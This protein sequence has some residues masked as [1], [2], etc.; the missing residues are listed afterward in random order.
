[1][2]V[3]VIYS[4][5]AFIQR[6]G[7]VGRQMERDFPSLEAAQNAPLPEGYTFGFIPVEDGR[8][9]YHSPAF[10]WEFHEEITKSYV[11]KRVSEWLERLIDLFE[12][13]KK[14]ASKNGWTTE[15]GPSIPMFEELMQRFGVSEH[16]Q[17]T[18]SICDP[19]GRRIWI[20]PKGLWV[21]GANGRVD[22]FSP[23]GA[24][25]LVDMEAKLGRQPRWVIH[26]IGNSKGQAFSPELLAEMI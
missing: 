20:K 13:I 25:T 6:A 8:Y 23:K 24:Y 2:T 17:P 15:D 10:G 7:D 14:W 9:V 11:E 26:Y 16:Q 21:I 1:M 19:K 22:L 4:T 18:M 12:E 3:R 5:D